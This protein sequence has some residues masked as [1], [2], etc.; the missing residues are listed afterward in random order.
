MGVV[1]RVV[2][3]REG[4]VSVAPY[5]SFNLGDHVGDDPQAVAANRSRLARHVGLPDER[6]VWME[7]IHSPTITVVIAVPPPILQLAVTDAVASLP[8]VGDPG[9]EDTHGRGLNILSAIAQRWGVD[10]HA[11]DGKT[12][13][14]VFS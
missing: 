14:A 13:W 5:D 12:I 1:R 6:V 9:L 4:G 7:Q 11:D 8:M 10:S 3:T 2:T